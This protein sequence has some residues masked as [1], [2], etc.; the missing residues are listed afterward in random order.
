MIRPVVSLLAVIVVAVIGVVWITSTW[1]EEGPPFEAS[2]TQGAELLELTGTTGR[3]AGENH[4]RTAVAYAQTIYAAAQDKDRPGAVVLVR[5]DDP[6]TAIAATRLQH[7][8]VNAPMLFVTDSGNTLPDATRDELERLGPEGVMMDNNVQVYLVGDIDAAVAH[9]IEVELEL[10][11]RRIVATDPILFAEELDE[12]LAVLDSNHADVMLVGAL[13]A[14]DYSTCASN[15]N[16]HMGEGFAF[17]TEERVPAATRRMLR[18]RAPSYPY[19]YVFAPED[20]IGAE[21]MAELARYGH[22][23]RIP[24]HTPQEMC[25][26]WAGYKDAGRKIGWWFGKAARA[27]GWGYA[28]PGHNTLLG[29][30][31]DWRTIVPSGVLSHMGKH[32]MLLLTDEDGSL[33]EVVESYLTGPLKPTRTHPSQQVF[34]HGWVLGGEDEVSDATMRAYAEMLEIQGLREASVQLDAGAGA[35]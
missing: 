35:P 4:L 22:V 17:V 18:R 20:V 2:A 26:R 14:L 23:Q 1:H 10:K 9:E 30:P 7:M 27:P 5:D 13:G 29:N 21:V 8:P 19:I 6:A 24:G 25:V 28:E 31:T 33:P 12:F 16:A 3:L 32:A 34:N 15:W 11:T